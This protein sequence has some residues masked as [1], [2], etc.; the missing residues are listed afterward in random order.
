MATPTL[1]ANCTWFTQ[2]GTTVKRASITKITIVDSYTPTGSEKSSWDASAAK[3]GSVMAYVNGSELTIAGNGSG[4]VYANPD[5]SYVFSSSGSDSFVNVTAINGGNIF[6][7]SKATTFERMFNLC[8]KLESVDVSTWETQSVSSLKATFSQC[9]AL[10]SIAVDN[11]DTTNVLDMTATFQLATGLT[12]LD[13]SKWNVSKVTSMLNMFYGNEASGDMSLISV[14]DIGN[15]DVRNVKDMRW[16]FQRCSKL[17]E[18]NVDNWDT[19]SCVNMTGMFRNCDKLEKLN[20]GNWDTSSCVNMSSMFYRCSNLSNLNVSNWDTSSCENMYY[21]FYGCTSLEVLDVSNWD[22]SKVETFCNMFSGDSD[23]GNTPMIIRELDVS[24]WDTSSCTDMSFMFYG[25]TKKKTLDMSKWDVSK[26]TT[27]DHMFAHSGINVGDISHWSPGTACTNMNAMFWGVSNT[28]LDVS[29]FDTS[30]VQFFCQM[31]EN[32]SN[33]TE[34]IGLENFDTSNG[35]GF[36]GMF[37]GCGRLQRLNLSS[38]DTRKAKDNVT[39][40]ANGHKTLTLRHMFNGM[41]SLERIDFGP[42]FSFKGDGTT[43]NIERY[44]VLPTPDASYI[45]DADGNWYDIDKT[46]YAPDSVPDGT[47]T[48]FAS[49]SIADEADNKLVLVKQGTLLRTAKAIRDAKGV[50]ARYFPAEFPGAI[51]EVGT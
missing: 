20:V 51:R 1:A 15:W 13:L 30:N 50:S 26:V 47:G 40:S 29:N 9:F 32:A 46:A 23:Y 49:T 2:G 19:S 38:F 18:L 12:E 45:T 36:D 35:L 34:I 27:F 41:S 28:V 5:S 39:A 7:T 44:A 3:N 48:Y 43:T 24:N 17:E 8:K 4:N 42:N 21:M 25:C 6:D 31:F 11:W 33:L 37:K 16:M 14:G 22:V 10:N